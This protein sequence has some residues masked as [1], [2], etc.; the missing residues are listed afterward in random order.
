MNGTGSPGP[1]A[2]QVDG[3]AFSYDERFA[4]EDITFAVE[5]GVVTA[6]LGPNGAGKTTLFALITRLFESRIGR[7]KI[8]GHDLRADSRRALARIGVVFQQPTLDLDLTV[9]QNL[10]YFAALHGMA[11]T[12][13]ERRIGEELGRLGMDEYRNTRVRTLSGG[14]RRRTEIAR[15]MLHCPALLLLDE[16]T[17]GLDVPTRQRIVAHA[18]RLAREDGIAILWA[19]HLIDEV[20]EDDRL[21]VLHRGRV[22]ARGPVAE[23]RRTVA[24]ASLEEAFARLTGS[25]SKAGPAA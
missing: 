2:L 6:L 13:A 12:A 10:R 8:C 3:L 23:V 1:P 25:S 9:S 15:A 20:W 18:H 4:L 21:I 17:V 22:C 7:V 11:G 5:P 24:A 16:P 19:T 14:Y